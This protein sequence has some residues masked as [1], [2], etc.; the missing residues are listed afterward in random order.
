MPNLVTNHQS[1]ARENWQGAKPQGM[2]ANEPIPPNIYYDQ[3]NPRQQNQPP[4][5]NGRQVPPHNP[6]LSNTQDVRFMEGNA[7]PH[8]NEPSTSQA[9]PMEGP[10]HHWSPHANAITYELR[11]VYEGTTHEEPALAVTTRA[12]KG[13]APAEEELEGQENYSSDDVERPQFQDL[14]KVA[15]AARQATKAWAQENEILDGK[16]RH[17]VIQD[18]EGSSMGQWEG[19]GIPIDEFGSVQKPRMEKTC[20]YDLWTDLSSLKADI[21]FGQLLEISPLARKTLKEGMPVNRRVRKAKTRIAARVQLQGG[22]REVKAVEIEVM[23]V[24]K[25]V[26]NVLVDGGSGLNIMPEHTLKKLGLHLTGPSPFIINM[27]NQ[28]S[29]VPLGMVKDCRIQTGG[30]EYIVTFHVIK[31]HSTKDTFPILLGRPW[32]RMANAVVDWG[33]VKPSIT[34]GPDGNRSRVSIGSWGGWVRKEMTSSSDEGEED[35]EEKKDDEALVGAFHSEGQH[36]HD[37]CNISTMGP[38]FYLQ[39][40]QGE[41]HHWLRQY[42][43]SVFDTMTI[44]HYPRLQDETD[45]ARLEAYSVLE[46]C[47]VLTEEEWVKG[48]LTPWT[49]EVGEMEVGVVHVDGTQEEDAII[50]VEKLEE[51]LHFKTTSTGILVGHDVKDYPKVPPD[52]YRNT[53]EQTHVTEG[54]WK[55]VDV[56]LKNGKV[57]PMKMGSKLGDEEIREYSELIDEFSDTFA[58]SYDE[59]KGIPREMVEHRIPLIP[60]AKPV[61]Q[62]ERRM[63]PQLQLLVKAELERLLQAGFIKPVEITDWVS[64]MVI[65][66][67]KNGKLRVCVDYRKLNACTQ[68][69][70]FPLPFITLLLEEVGGHARYTFMDGYAGYN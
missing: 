18:L 41:F 8:A 35:T 49:D 3:T 43:E 68:K 47:E 61:R 53:E 36:S 34:Y 23:V 56:K 48:G 55:Y 42:P 11:G 51:P 20:G 38:G 62:K 1:N 24:D 17:N 58:W 37:H 50:E 39:E 70:H 52:W 6:G 22:I 29:S 57:R 13:S 5:G 66:K 16:R 32:L 12:M 21:T 4:A 7:D 65:V 27:A 46:P 26:P 54:D 63:N 40:D 10:S 60:G 15:N 31:M 9:M 67:K 30:E 44:C 14:E 28:T 33:G 2:N 25:V 64:P 19:P 59:L 69:D 45:S